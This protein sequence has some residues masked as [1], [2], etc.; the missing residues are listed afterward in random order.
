MSN[1][2]FMTG[3]GGFLYSPGGTG[4]AYDDTALAAR[5][6]A[7][8]GYIT[9][10]QSDVIWNRRT[11]VDGSAAGPGSSVLITGMDGTKK[12]RVVVKYL[13]SGGVNHASMEF[14]PADNAAE[15]DAAS[16]TLK[17]SAAGTFQGDTAKCELL[18]GTHIL[19][20]GANIPVEFVFELDPVNKKGWFRFEAGGGATPASICT[21][22]SGV[23]QWT[24]AA[25][26]S[27]R[28]N[29]LTASATMT[30]ATWKGWTEV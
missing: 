21:G 16:A 9:T 25:I 19:C 20:S 4:S 6:T 10:L 29:C 13:A 27:F 5:V 18:I 15:A 8:E 14:E 28:L 30:T 12:N 2:G 1:L 26:T 3:K 24:S 22:G 17:Y 23:L 7:A 11:G